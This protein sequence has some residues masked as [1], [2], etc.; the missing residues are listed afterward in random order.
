MYAATRAPLDLSLQWQHAF[1]AEGS[2]LRQ[3]FRAEGVNRGVSVAHLAELLQCNTQDLEMNEKMYMELIQ[4][5]EQD[6]LSLKNAELFTWLSILSG[7][8]VS[9]PSGC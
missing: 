1:K 9:A 5:F 8:R 4:L 7:G 3:A 6:R 2:G